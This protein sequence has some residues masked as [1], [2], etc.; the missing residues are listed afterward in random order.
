ML[1]RQE[2]EWDFRLEECYET[3][4]RGGKEEVLSWN[5]MV[6]IKSPWRV[7]GKKCW[8]GCWRKI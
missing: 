8:E 7:S 6:G 5:G 4:H 2:Q 1:G 3:S